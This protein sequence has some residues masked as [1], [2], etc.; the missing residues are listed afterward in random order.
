VAPR[1]DE[2]VET[3]FSPGDLA[4]LRDVVET[5]DFTPDGV[6]GLLGPAASA[7]LGRGDVVPALRATRGCSP[8]ETL[9]RLFVCGTTEPEVVVT[10]A[11]TPFPVE[12]ALA[13]GLLEP[14]TGGLRA[15]LDL[16]PYGDDLGTWWVFS[17]LGSDVRPG[18]LAADHV[19]GVGGAS[20]TLAQATVRVPAA[21]ALDLGTGCG[22]QSLHLSRHVERVT[23]TDLSSRALRM[24][25]TTAAFNG[26]DWELLAGDMA[27]P[28]AGRRFDL[29]VSNPP[30]VVGPGTTTHTYRDSGRSGDGMGAELV[31]AAPDLLNPGGWLQLLANWLHREGEPWDERVAGWLPARCDAWVVQREVLDPAEYVQMWLRDAGESGTERAS[32][33]LDWF[34]A[35]RVEAVGFG[36]VTVRASDVDSPVQRLEDLRQVVDQPLGREVLAWFARQ[37]HVRDT[38]LLDSRLRAHPALVLRQEAVPDTDGWDVTRQVLAAEGGL[39]WTQEVDPVVVALVGGCDGTSTLRDQLTLLAAAYDTPAEQLLAA[40]PLVVGPLVERGLLLPVDGS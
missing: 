1:Q 18:P 32:A 16:R 8:L 15:R 5:A 38:G 37:D 39:R 35:E 13:A 23:A 14:A 20:V 36:L 31:A 34:A 24:A 22:V 26:M 40:A 11:F 29:V 10:A 19:L 30:F 4:R 33:W 6:A 17:D 7:A 28:V 2:A 25:A 9:V 12:A 3:L 27:G 21:T